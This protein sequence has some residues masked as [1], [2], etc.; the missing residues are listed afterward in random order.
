MNMKKTS[1]LLASQSLRR[2]ELI[3]LLGVDFEIASANV[4]ESL[5]P[6]ES[7]ADYVTRLAE[8]KAR[9]FPPTGA[10]KGGRVVIGSDTVVVDIGE[11]LGKPRDTRDA[12]LTLRR[13]RGRTHQVYT[14][15]AVY[16]ETSKKIFSELS[17]SDVPMRD[18]SDAE[19]KSYIATGDP[20]DKAGGYAIQHPD[21][22][23]VEKFT[24]CFAS[25]M[26]LP[27]C[28]LARILRKAG[29]PVDAKMPLRCQSALNYACEVSEAILRGK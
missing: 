1:L 20:M 29:V 11:T 26:G 8:A 24:G 23:P 2:R 3:A 19:I 7:P 22:Q 17:I 12:E 4:D 25:V 27:L 28:H 18:Y 5:F 6:N 10:V 9:A 15:V 13:L 16:D 14:A 21:F